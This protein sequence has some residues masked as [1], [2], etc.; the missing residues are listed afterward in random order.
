MSQE[1]F[2]KD[3]AEYV[4]KVFLDIF[5]GFK[6]QAEDRIFKLE[7]TVEDLE[8]QIAT[9]VVGYGEQ[10]V[11]MEALVAQ[12]AFNGEEQQKAFTENLAQARDKMLEVMQ[13]APSVMGDGYTGTSSAVA[14]LAAEKLSDTDQ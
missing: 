10:A 2:D 6:A 9:L 1:H 12:I 3:T 8:K 11:F 4:A 13:D 7:Q 5:E 14:N